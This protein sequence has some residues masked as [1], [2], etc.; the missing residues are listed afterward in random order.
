MNKPLSSEPRRATSTRDQL[1]EVIKTMDFKINSSHVLLIKGARS[2]IDS[3]GA[4]TEA[5]TRTVFEDF[6]QRIGELV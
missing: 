4:I 2:K 5:N 3:T 6:C 1:I